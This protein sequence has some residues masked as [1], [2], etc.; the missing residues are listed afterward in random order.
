MSLGKV[1]VGREC[2]PLAWDMLSTSCL[3]SSTKRCIS[4]KLD[5]RFEEICRLPFQ[6]WGLS[7]ARSEDEELFLAAYSISYFFLFYSSTLKTETICSSETRST[8]NGSNIVISQ[9]TEFFM[10][11]AVRTFDHV[12]SCLTPLQF[13]LTNYSKLKYVFSNKS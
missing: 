9:E 12:N 4:V 10:N 11:T 6:S 1:L 3:K 2:N 13:Y 5:R 8:F 7:Q